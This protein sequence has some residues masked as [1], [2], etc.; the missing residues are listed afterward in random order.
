MRITR[1]CAVLLLVPALITFVACGDDDAGDADRTTS[2]TSAPEAPE[3][4]S[5]TTSTLTDEE[6]SSRV[7]EARAGLQAA[8]GDLCGIVEAPPLDAVPTTS[9]QMEEWVGFN[10][11]V[12]EFAA[13]ALE[14][15]DP[16]SAEAMRSAATALARHAE[17]AGYPAD[18][19]SDVDSLPEELTGPAYAD[20]ALAMQQKV[21]AECS[22]GL[23]GGG[24]DQEG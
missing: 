19:L 3:D 21:S 4:S 24:T 10:V 20:A 2:S 5:T 7:A 9:A 1:T 6:F 15:D 16:Q 17:E 22:G 12:L 11:E 18:L 13:T 14:G 8:E 23:G